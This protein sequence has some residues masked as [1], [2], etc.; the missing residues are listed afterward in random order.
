MCILSTV[1]K[2]NNR[3]ECVF[4]TQGA[5]SRR[6]LCVLLVAVVAFR[7]AVRCGFTVF[8][9]TKTSNT[10]LA[11]NH[12]ARTTQHNNNKKNIYIYIK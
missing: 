4:C 10:T 9:L 2:L 11:S 1:S 3:I 5:E 7:F 12:Q 8:P 6:C